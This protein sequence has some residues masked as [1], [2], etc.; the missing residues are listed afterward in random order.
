MCMYMYVHI[1]IYIYLS[2]LFLVMN[3]YMHAAYAYRKSQC[4]AHAMID[5]Q[6]TDTVLI[7]ASGSSA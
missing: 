6:Y 1:Y 7:M 3:F 5:T 2:V 4:M